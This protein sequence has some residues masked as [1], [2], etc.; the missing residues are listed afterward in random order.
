MALSRCRCP[1]R[2]CERSFSGSLNLHHFADG[3]AIYMVELKWPGADRSQF[4]TNNKTLYRRYANRPLRLISGDVKGTITDAL[5]YHSAPNDIRRHR[6]ISISYVSLLPCHGRG[7]GFESRRPRHPFPN[8]TSRSRSSSFCLLLTALG[9]APREDSL[10]SLPAY[11][12]C[13][14]GQKL[15]G[16]IF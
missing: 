5:R 3:Q 12:S 14:T 9:V 16:C 2:E 8:K 11:L 6:L 7:R 15:L 1:G 4:R 10:C 13:E